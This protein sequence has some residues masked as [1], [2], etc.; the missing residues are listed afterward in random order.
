MPSGQPSLHFFRNQPEYWPVNGTVISSLQSLET[1]FFLVA[2]H[3]F[4][5][6]LIVCTAAIESA[7][8]AADIG[9]KERDGFQEL[10]RKARKRSEGI[11]DFGDDGLNH[12]RVVRNRITH[13]GFSPRDDSE[14]TDLYIRVALPFLSLGFPRSIRLTSLAACFQSLQTTLTSLGG[15]IPSQKNCRM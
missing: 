11:E 5:H 2:L 15:S 14:T 9:A 7:M 4:P 10:L 12:L 8:Q 13:H 1:S 6:A 3:R